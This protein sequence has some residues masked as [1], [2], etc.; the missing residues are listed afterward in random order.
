VLAAKDRPE[1]LTQEQQAWDVARRDGA[2]WTMVVG[3]DLPHAFDALDPSESSRRLVAQTVDYLVRQLA[4]PPPPPGWDPPERQE[5]VALYGQDYPATLGILRTRLAKNPGD[6]RAAGE[7]AR[8]LLLQGDR[9]SA[10]AEY[11]KLLQRTD[12]EPRQRALSLY[13]LACALALTLKRDAA[14]T[15]LEEAVAAGFDDRAMLTTD[16]DL[17]TLRQEPRYQALEKK[18]ASTTSR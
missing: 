3:R 12:V 17:E 18:L 1:L 16:P 6:N 9:R 5:L 10:I 11:E 8:V 4:T 13:N 15:R 14:V 7:L 2:P